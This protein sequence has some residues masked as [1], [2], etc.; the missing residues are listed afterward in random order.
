MERSLPKRL[1]AELI[2]TFGLVFAGTGAIVVDQWSGGV[3]THVGIC[4]TFGLVV[5]AMIL[6]AGHISGAH[7]NP[8]VT[9]AFWGAGRFPGRD[10][11]PYV[12]AQL[13][14]ASAAS[15][16]VLALIGD[17]GRLGATLPAGSA[18]QALGLELL[19]TFFLMF[20]I[21]AVAT[22]ARANG[23][24]AALAIGGTVAFEALF[25]GPV[26][27]ASMNPARSFGPALVGGYF[28]A[29]WVYWIGPIAGALAAGR[30]YDWFRGEPDGTRR[31]V[32]GGG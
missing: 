11:A 14:G 16:A 18:Q 2:A 3:V 28:T 22:D 15:L 23:Q 6:A 9:L 31:P 19:L 10:V 13:A 24:M 12:A 1:T 4:L 26:S 5:A 32:N 30:L 29:H 25:A 17:H 7:I 21:M 8:A 20:V 27:G